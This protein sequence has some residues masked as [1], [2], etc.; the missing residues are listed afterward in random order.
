LVG[1]ASLGSFTLDWSGTY[2]YALGQVDGNGC[3]HYTS[4]I[5]PDG[6]IVDPT[7]KGSTPCGQTASGIFTFQ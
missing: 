2:A 4:A 7:I 3:H 6:A 5:A 1:G